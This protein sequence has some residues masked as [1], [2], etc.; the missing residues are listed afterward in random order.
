MVC[1][2]GSD[3]IGTHGGNKQKIRYFIMCL[4]FLSSRF[5]SR[6]LSS[7]PN[8]VVSSSEEHMPCQ[9]IICCQYNSRILPGEVGAVFAAGVWSPH[10]WSDAADVCES[11]CRHTRKTSLFGKESINMTNCLIYS[12]LY[13]ILRKLLQVLKCLSYRIVL[14]LFLS[15]LKLKYH[16]NR[17]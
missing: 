12:C 17:E 7:S 15:Q 4:C 11:T 2:G 14:L 8:D 9:C 5:S 16:W 6:V 1:V 10:P 3:L 13:E